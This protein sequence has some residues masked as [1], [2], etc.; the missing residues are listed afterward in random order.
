MTGHC[1]DFDHEAC[2]L[3]VNLDDERMLIRRAR[4]SRSIVSHAD[5]F[6]CSGT[7]TEPRCPGESRLL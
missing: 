1:V 4:D 7:V 2:T 3:H 6:I 5:R